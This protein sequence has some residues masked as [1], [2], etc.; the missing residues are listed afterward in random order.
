MPQLA[1]NIISIAC[2]SGTSSKY[3]VNF[4]S[5]TASVETKI[6]ASL[7]KSDKLKDYGRFDLEIEELEAWNTMNQEKIETT[8]QKI[9]NK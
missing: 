8:N 5:L 1:S 6:T 2:T 3:R 9:E 7:T 4:L